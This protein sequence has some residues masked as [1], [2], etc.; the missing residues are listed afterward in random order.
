MDEHGFPALERFFEKRSRTRKYYFIS[1]ILFWMGAV[2]S[3]GYFISPTGTVPSLVPGILMLSG[4][5][6]YFFVQQ[7]NK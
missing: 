7:R 1:A 2:F 6:L 4:V 5:A 3:L